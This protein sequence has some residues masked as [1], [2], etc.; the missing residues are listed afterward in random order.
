MKNDPLFLNP[1][2]VKYMLDAYG[3]NDYG[4]FLSRRIVAVDTYF[5]LLRS[6]QNQEWAQ[7][8]Y[9]A[10]ES[11]TVILLSSYSFTCVVWNLE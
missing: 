5:D 4:T 9:V 2:A 7:D 1:N 3:L 8:T 11:R 10:P 6:R